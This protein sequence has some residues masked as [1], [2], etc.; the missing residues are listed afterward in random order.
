MKRHRIRLVGTRAQG[1]R[2]SATALRDVL[3]ALITGARHAVRFRVDG[4]GLAGSTPG[5]L[6]RVTEMDVLPLEP[7]STVVVV[8]A[9]TLAAAAPERFTQLDFLLD[10][11]PKATA[12]EVM[13]ESLADALAPRSD[14]ERF[15]AGLLKTFRGFGRLWRH[16][17]EHL[18]LDGDRP[19]RLDS[20]ATTKLER[21]ERQI[22]ADQR[23]VVVGTLDQLHHSRR[24]FTVRTDDGRDVR[25]VIGDEMPVA[26]LGALFGQRAIV[27][28]IARFRASGDVFFVEADSVDAS[29]DSSSVFSRV[30][31]PALR[32][33]DVR[34]LTRSQG[35]R[36]GVAAILGSWPGD[37]TEDEARA[38][39]DE[40]S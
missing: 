15:D 2:L 16:G 25:G 39:L 17:I 30:P 32:A 14:S 22:P 5:W 9:P 34:S 1:A 19:L 28:G 24:A 38:I 11:D 18:E 21:L 35:P 31:K 4:K 13:A 6:E 10:L 23:V 36:S 7:G 29:S 12:V 37:E 3:D 26:P 33:L 27:S 40:M 20:S 8:E